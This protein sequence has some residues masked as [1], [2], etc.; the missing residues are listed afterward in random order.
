MRLSDKDIEKW[1]D[2]GLLK[3]HPEPEKKLINGATVDIKLGNK[4]RIFQKN[5]IN[6]IDLSST[7]EVM[8]NILDTVMSPEI[9]L[10]KNDYFF[11]KPSS[12]ALAVTEEKIILP[13]NL[14]GWLDGRSSL[15]RLGL[16][17]HATSHRIDPGWV[18]KIV[19]EFFNSGKITLA[20]KP[21]M[22]IGAISFEILSSFSIRP[23]NIRSGTKYLNQSSVIQIKN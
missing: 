15:A 13:N 6:F 22:L 7:K 18:G 5:K 11:L 14:I 21:G 19:L 4:F 17:V 3:I 2:S 10:S 8:N 9:I 16:M 12:F 1:L 23:Y 20:L